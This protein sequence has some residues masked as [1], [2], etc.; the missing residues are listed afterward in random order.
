MNQVVAELEQETS[1]ELCGICSAHAI[2]LNAPSLKHLPC[3]EARRLWMQLPSKL[4]SEDGVKLWS[5][6]TEDAVHDCSLCLGLE[7]VCAI[8]IPA[9]CV[10]S[11]W[12]W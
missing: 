3:A 7:C 1:L 9:V 5:I 11:V 8:Y 2:D 12:G 6:D 10:E 4:D